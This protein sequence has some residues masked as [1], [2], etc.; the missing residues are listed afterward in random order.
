MEDFSFLPTSP[1]GTTS[2]GILLSAGFSLALAPLW[3]R[4]QKRRADALCIPDPVVPLEAFFGIFS[5]RVLI[6]AI[7]STGVRRDAGAVDALAKRMKNA[8]VEVAWA[9][10]D[11]WGRNRNLPPPYAHTPEQALTGPEKKTT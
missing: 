1:P 3:Q 10:T 4:N 6:G 5:I 2:E 8:D 11:A 9:A 7:D